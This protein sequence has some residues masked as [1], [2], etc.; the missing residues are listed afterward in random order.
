MNQDD[1][2]AQVEQRAREADEEVLTEMGR[3]VIAY[4]EMVAALEHQSVLGIGG[5]ATQKQAENSRQYRLLKA[6]I[7]RGYADQARETFSAVMGE[8]G[9]DDWDDNDRGAIKSLYNEIKYLMCLRNRLVHDAWRLGGEDVWT[10]S[11]WGTYSPGLAAKRH[12]SP[13]KAGLKEDIDE[14]GAGSLFESAEEVALVTRK[15]NE[16]GESTRSRALGEDAPR[17]SGLPSF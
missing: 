9:Q 10:T 15:I 8:L 1:F 4:S 6:A 5:F 16:L 7:F 17:P 13:S 3:F 12:I 11:G 14:F 2:E